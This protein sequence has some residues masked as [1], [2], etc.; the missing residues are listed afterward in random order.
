[1]YGVFRFIQHP[2]SGAL[3]AVIVDRGTVPY[4]EQPTFVKNDS[5]SRHTIYVLEA[6]TVPGATPPGRINPRTPYTTQ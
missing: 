5:I 2:L 4:I 3:E 1:L 6:D